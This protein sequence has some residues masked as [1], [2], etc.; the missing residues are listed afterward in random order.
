MCALNLR[1]NQG[2]LKGESVVVTILPSRM[3][4]IIVPLDFF[5]VKPVKK[6]C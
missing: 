2:N 5:V 3:E 6:L 4:V 1:G